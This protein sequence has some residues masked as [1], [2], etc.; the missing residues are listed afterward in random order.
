MADAR[1]ALLPITAPETGYS[2]TGGKSVSTF[3]EQVPESRCCPR[4]ATPSR[5]GARQQTPPLHPEVGEIEQRHQPDD[6][7]KT[8][9]SRRL[10][11]IRILFS[12]K[13]CCQRQTIGAADRAPPRRCAAF[14]PESG[15]ERISMMQTLGRNK[16]VKQGRATVHAGQP[17]AI[18]RPPRAAA[19]A[20][21]QPAASSPE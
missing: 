1:S 13:R 10:F 20:A 9:F 4:T 21:G 19:A 18:A 12:A 16:P 6:A 14:L 11:H 17:P 5:S 3:S 7:T 15:V 2:G 8:V